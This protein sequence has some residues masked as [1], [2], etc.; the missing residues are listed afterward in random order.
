MLKKVPFLSI[1]VFVIV[2]ACFLA[3]LITYVETDKFWKNEVDRLLVSSRRETTKDLSELM[4]TVGNNYV[5][6]TESSVLAEGV[7][8]GYVDAL[9]DR[10]SMY[11]DEKS[12]QDFKAFENSAS[13]EGIG[14]STLYDSTREGLYIINVYKGSPAEQS[15]IVPGDIITHIDGSFVGNMGYYSVMYK[16]GGGREDDKVELAVRKL[17]GHSDVLNI[18]RSKVA[19]EGITHEKLGDGVGFVRISRFGIGDE[20]AFKA[21]LESLIRAGCEKFVLDVRNNPG[22]DI[23]TVSRILDFVLGDGPVFTVADKSGATNTFTSDTSALP[24]PIAVLVNENTVCEAEV[25]AKALSN[26]GAAT[27]FGVPT[28]G[29]ASSQSVY[30]LSNGGAASI[31]TLKYA[32]VGSEDFDGIGIIPDVTVALSDELKSRFTTITHAEDSQLQAAVDYI[33]TKKI[34]D[35]HD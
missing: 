14:V 7:M 30:P 20:S 23:E 15:G 9:P 27:L 4:D 10:F 21:A 6:P 1:I 25:F 12:Y 24:Y 34:F 35:F 3:S 11:M 33:K 29:K 5:Y 32:L 19:S 26:F 2:A 22:G 17:D 31:S 18:T 28:Y 13:N 16:L 8:K